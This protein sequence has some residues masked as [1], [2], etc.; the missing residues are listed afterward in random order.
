MG[1]NQSEGNLDRR[2][3]L[4]AGMGSLVVLAAG[5]LAPAALAADGSAKADK[6]D[7]AGSA[8]DSAAVDAASGASQATN[9]FSNMDRSE[10]M[11]AIPTMKGCVAVATTN[12]DGS[13]NLAVFIPS[14]VGE[15]YVYFGFAPNAT[16]AN[17]TRDKQAVVLYDEYDISVENPAQRH[18]GARLVV[19]LVDD[20]KTLAGLKDDLGSYGDAATVCEVVEVLPI[21]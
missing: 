13:P 18:H 8:K 14:A 16:L 17:L 2:S 11:A 1:S 5:A 19:R 20:E 7:K 9:K 10:V 6:A 4:G 21:G 12:E 3:F 15:D